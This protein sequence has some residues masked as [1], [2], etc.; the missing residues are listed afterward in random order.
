MD[1]SYSRVETSGQVCKGQTDP[2][3][4]QRDPALGRSVV[5]STDP[6]I[7]VFPIQSPSRSLLPRTERQRRTTFW[8][9]SGRGGPV[10]RKISLGCGRVLK[11]DEAGR[12]WPPQ[13]SPVWLGV[14]APFPLTMGAAGWQH[15]LGLDLAF[16]WALPKGPASRAASDRKQGSG[17]CSHRLSTLGLVGA[18]CAR[19]S[20]SRSP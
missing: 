9:S 18:P 19:L 7:S 13:G 16:P 6:K 4:Q 17:G 1:G 12:C 5:W 14:P 2:Q 8:Q 10:L 20:G 11:E 3:V 15:L